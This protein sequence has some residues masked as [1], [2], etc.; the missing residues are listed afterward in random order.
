MDQRAND[1]GVAS[2]NTAE[3]DVAN[4][5]SR[6]P[7]ARA[8]PG[9]GR[10][11]PG[12]ARTT[13]EPGD[14][15]WAATEHSA[16]GVGRCARPRQRAASC[17]DATDELARAVAAGDARR[18]LPLLIDRY[19]LVVYHY[20][21]RMLSDGDDGDDV[22]Q[23]VFLHAFEVIQRRQPIDNLRAYLLG[24][25]RYRCLDRLAVRRSA[26]I[27]IDAHELERTLDSEALAACPTSDP[28]MSEALD[29]SLDELDPR[30]RTVLLLRFQDG[31]S[32]AEISQLTGDR[33]GA[34]RVR[35][36]RALRLLRRSLERREI[37]F[38][39]DS[40]PGRRS[41]GQAPGERGQ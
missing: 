11:A 39:A 6:R 26:P 23:I 21:R 12:R 4:R 20:C 32:Y 18:A 7:R 17:D 30:S 33:P 35:V 31:L 13:P 9:R 25:A 19:G 10:A 2:A 29:E 8:G 27:L 38:D 15:E 14:E 37:W 40:A 1:A 36:A 3:I 28:R 5:G 41:A 24:I 16:P 34:L 22:S